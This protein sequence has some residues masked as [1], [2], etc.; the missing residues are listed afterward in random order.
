VC[1][2]PP[3]GVPTSPQQHPREIRGGDVAPRY[4]STHHNTLIYHSLSTTPSLIVFIYLFIYYVIIGVC[5]VPP[6]GVPTSPQQHPRE[7]RDGDV[8]PRYPST[9]HT[10]TPPHPHPHTTLTHTTPLPHPQ[11]NS[12]YL[13]INELIN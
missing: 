12:I 2:V 6:H 8:V 3:H 5:T 1:A 10:P 4:S 7:I 11:S 9:H 13:F